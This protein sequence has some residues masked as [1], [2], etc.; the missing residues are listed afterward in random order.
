MAEITDTVLD[1]LYRCERVVKEASATFQ[2][3]I[4]PEEYV[5]M[6][7]THGAEDVSTVL[8]ANAPQGR[9]RRS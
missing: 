4:T 2:P 8:P 1:W 9:P 3:P 7:L 5:T 6:C